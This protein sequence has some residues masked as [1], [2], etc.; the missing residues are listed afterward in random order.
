MNFKNILAEFINNFV[1]SRKKE[2][3][4]KEFAYD[5]VLSVGEHCRPMYYLKKHGLRFCANPLD[6]MGFYSLDAVIHLFKTGFNDFFEDFVK[7]EQKS[8]QD[9]YNWY[10]DTKNNITSRYYDDVESNNAD[11]REK[12]KNRFEKINKILLNANKICFISCRNEDVD[13]FKNFLH[14]M[15]KMYSGRIT[16]INIRDNREIDNVKFYKEKI[17]EKSD[18]IEY[19]FK[20]VHPDGDDLTINKDAWYGN[21]VIWDNIIEKISICSLKN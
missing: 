11:F 5:I 14:E 16:F 21:Y 20:D 9:N 15:D 7:D 8:L 19:E 13:V 17:S 12:M 18:L 4:Q 2:K 10:Y 1:K 6:S 3:S